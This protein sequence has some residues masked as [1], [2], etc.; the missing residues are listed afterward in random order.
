[1]R[2]LHVDNIAYVA[3]NIVHE[4]RRRKHDTLL[5]GLYHPAQLP[6]DV[7]IVPGG[8]RTDP[9]VM[10][11][12]NREE[13]REI[14]KRIDDFDI[15]HV[16][17]G[18]GYAG[19]YYWLK[20]TFG[21]KKIVIHFHGSDI[22]IKANTKFSS[23]GNILLVSTPDLLKCGNNVGGK[24]LIHIPNPSYL[25]KMKPVGVEKRT[26]LAEKDK[27]VIAHMPTLRKFKGTEE[28]IK[29]VK[30]LKKKYPIE[31]NLIENADHHTAQKRLKASDICIDWVS[32]KFDIYGMVSI[33]A[34]SY[35]IPTICRFNPDYYNPPII[36]A[37]PNNIKE[38]IE[39]LINDR[40]L[41]LKTSR[42]SRKYVEKVHDVRKVVD[43]IEKHYK[44][45]L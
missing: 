41:Y 27:I 3:Y 19:M 43:K 28:I 38:K 40:A 32:K 16:H 21:G 12:A 15:I 2:I 5:I 9:K 14:R 44:R 35:G 29:A 17:G 18:V 39:E 42:K 7:A 1:M 34:M 24:E 37:E 31:L 10:K 30:K 45:I 13:F 26:P 36:N 20:K 22:R 6:C 23:V 8:D 11:K 25:E 33:E 4:L